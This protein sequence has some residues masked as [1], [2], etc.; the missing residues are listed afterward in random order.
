MDLLHTPYCLVFCGDMIPCVDANNTPGAVAASSVAAP[1]VSQQICEIFTEQAVPLQ[2][3]RVCDT[4][5]TTNEVETPRGSL[6]LVLR[7]Y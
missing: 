3:D 1:E 2:R 7:K 5:T 6:M 4:N